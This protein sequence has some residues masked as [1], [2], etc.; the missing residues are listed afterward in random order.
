M[1]LQNN[2]KFKGP[3]YKG[4]LDIYGISQDPNTK[5]YILVMRYANHGSLRNYI[6][7][8][9][10]DLYW[11]DKIRILYSIIF[12]LNII[13]QEQLIHHDLH[14]GNILYFRWLPQETMIADLGLSVSADQ[15]PSSIVGV[16][17][18]IAPEVLNGKP[19]TQKSDIYSFG[20]LMSEIS[21]GQQPFNDK[22]HGHGLM[23]KI[24]EGLR[25]AFSNNTPKFYIEFAYK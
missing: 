5:E 3:H 13:H 12:G 23:L 7:K 10:K 20:I 21:T 14:S 4:V 25:P 2:I 1:K 16:V 17:P 18:Y 8:R 22:A 11:K 6:T 15:E 24:C 19:Y 9:F